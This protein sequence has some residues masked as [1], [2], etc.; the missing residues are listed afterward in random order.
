M[1]ACLGCGPTRRATGSPSAAAA[2]AR[3]ARAVTGLRV[4]GAPVS[5]RLAA[6]GTVADVQA[7]AWLDVDVRLTSARGLRLGAA[8]RAPHGEHLGEVASGGAGGG[9]YAGW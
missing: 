6:D 1:T 7:P 3:S 5:V 2:R 4:A 9:S 8:Q